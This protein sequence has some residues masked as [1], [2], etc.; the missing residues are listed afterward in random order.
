MKNIRNYLNKFVE[1]AYWDADSEEHLIYSGRLIDI[2]Y[3]K[4]QLTLSRR[5]KKRF[6][7]MR[8]IDEIFLAYQPNY[9]L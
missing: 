6:L 5:R 9:Q 1:L 7:P 4:D 3:Q 8:R 2:D